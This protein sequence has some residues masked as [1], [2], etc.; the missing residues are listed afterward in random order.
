METRQDS[1]EYLSDIS[2]D[3][4][5]RVQRDLDS[6]EYDH[7]QIDYDENG[8]II[9][10][11]LKSASQV[12]ET[13]S[14]VCMDGVF[15]AA[16]YLR[17]PYGEMFVSVKSIVRIGADITPKLGLSHA[18]YS[19]EINGKFGGI[20]KSRNPKLTLQPPIYETPLALA[21][22]NRRIIEGYIELC[23]SRNETLLRL[24]AYYCSIYS[25]FKSYDNE[26]IEREPHE[27]LEPIL[28]G[29]RLIT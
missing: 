14:C 4:I 22:L 5:K 7:S 26:V 21:L 27:I 23:S 18:L 2:C 6:F 8:K 1:E 11:R 3:M 29:C 12:F 28:S 9:D 16:R 24:E 25:K 10:V 13:K 17:E 20:G 19:F 15:F